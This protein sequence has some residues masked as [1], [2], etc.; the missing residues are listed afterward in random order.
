MFFYLKKIYLNLTN[1][2]KICNIK[3]L[4]DT[5]VNQ[6]IHCDLKPENIMLNH[7]KGDTKEIK[8]IDFG[9]ACFE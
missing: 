1:T 4:K 9:S 5:R 6:I 8:I 2:Y 3:G 7:S